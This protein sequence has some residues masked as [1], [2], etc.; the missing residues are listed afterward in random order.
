MP[1]W[2]I[3]PDAVRVVLGNTRDQAEKLG[4][5]LQAYATTM[6]SAAKSAGTMIQG[7]VPKDGAFGPVAGALGEFGHNTQ[8]DLKFL[9]VR[10]VK[11][12]GGAAEATRCYENGALEMAHN[13]QHAAAQ[14]PTPEELK[15]EDKK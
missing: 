2:D 3:K 13:A 15:G 14:A 12:I 4:E 1:G 11:S 9:M 8:D 10:S 7:E 6:E 5:E